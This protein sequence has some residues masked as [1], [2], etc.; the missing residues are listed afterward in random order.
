MGSLPT[1]AVWGVV[2]ACVLLSPVLA[3]L[4]AIAVEILIDALVEAGAPAFFALVAAAAGGRFLIRK[5]RPHGGAS[6]E[7]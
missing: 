5:L 6:A 7:T 3:I 1:W 2:V 4:L